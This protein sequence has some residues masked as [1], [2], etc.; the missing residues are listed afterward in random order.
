VGLDELSAPGRHCLGCVLVV[1]KGVGVFFGSAGEH[2]EHQVLAGG[3]VE[4]R[5]VHGEQ[6]ASE[7]D[8]DSKFFP[9]A[10]SDAGAAEV[11]ERAEIADGT[12][13]I[14]EEEI[15]EGNE[16]DI[17]KFDV[18]GGGVVEMS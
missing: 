2:D 9:D 18:G 14:F 12:L 1:G 17:G 11:D 6:G 16:R 13:K 8:L 7:A 5:V 3:G 15:A 10:A 4:A